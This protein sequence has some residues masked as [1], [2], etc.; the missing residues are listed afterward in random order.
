[1][2]IISG[3][4]ESVSNTKIF[5]GVNK[6]KTQQLTIYANNVDNITT[7]NM[8]ILPVPF[9]ETVN[10]YDLSNYVNFFDDC[11]ECFENQSLNLSRGFSVSANYSVDSLEVHDVGS[12]KASLAMNLN[13]LNNANPKYFYLS[14]EVKEYLAE[15]YNHKS[16]GFILCLL[17]LGNKEYHPF[18]YSHKIINK[19]VYIPTR[20]FHLHKN[21]NSDYGDY[22][23]FAE[24]DPRYAKNSRLDTRDDNYADDWSHDIY[25]YNVTTKGNNYID[26]IHNRLYKWN[27]KNKVRFDKLDFNLDGNCRHF[28]KINIEGRCK[29]IDIILNCV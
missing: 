17:V 14:P 8:M 10:F 26:K 29:N 20:H 5:C 21:D 4:I 13:D 28:Q 3:E 18:A 27:K 25:L 15:H 16:I 2:C 12:Y 11:D 19:R 9:P 22:S 1:M 23:N 6:N 7:N 24:L